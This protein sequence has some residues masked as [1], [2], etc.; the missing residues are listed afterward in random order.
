[1]KIHCFSCGAVKGLRGEKVDGGVRVSCASCGHSW[2]R[3]KDMCDSCGSDAVAMVR[4]PLI[5]KSRGVQQSIIGYRT[6][7]ECQ[8]CGAQT[9][10]TAPPANYTKD[11]A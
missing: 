8:A 4:V 7:R 2:L 5:Q 1:M 10:S 11:D 3:H 9:G 6:I